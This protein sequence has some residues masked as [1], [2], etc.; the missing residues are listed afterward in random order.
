MCAPSDW[1]GRRAAHF[2]ADANER[3]EQLE[4]PETLLVDATHEPL[5]DDLRIRV[6]GLALLH[7]AARH[8]G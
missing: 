4:A 8:A 1:C 7:A 5:G 2:S 3:R 6:H